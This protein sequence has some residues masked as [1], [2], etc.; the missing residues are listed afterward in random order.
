VNYIK[1]KDFRAAAGAAAS[2]TSCVPCCISHI[3][4]DSVVCHEACSICNTVEE[5][6]EEE[7]E[8][9]LVCGSYVIR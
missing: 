8:D 3:P 9:M 2:D 7:E 6:E 1:A 5:E 4:R